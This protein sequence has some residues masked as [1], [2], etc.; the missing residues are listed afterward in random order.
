[1][2]TRSGLTI[3]AAGALALG[4]V[5]L[6]VG[7]PAWSWVTVFILAGITGAGAFAARA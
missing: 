6:A 1:M 2:D 3:A 7:V 4:V 5:L